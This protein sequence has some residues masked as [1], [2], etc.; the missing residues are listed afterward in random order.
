MSTHTCPYGNYIPQKDCAI[1]VRMMPN[2][3]ETV[4][5]P[6][7]SDQRRHPA[8]TSNTD[9]EVEVDFDSRALQHRQSPRR[10]STR[11]RAS[12]RP[13]FL[14]LLAVVIN[15]LPKTKWRNHIKLINTA[16]TAPASSCRGRAHP[17]PSSAFLSSLPSL[18]AC[19]QPIPHTQPLYPKPYPPLPH[20]A[21]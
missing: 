17:A 6:S 13:I 4:P 10:I 9:V 1:P 15:R 12:A 14:T 18:T 16:T 7:G 20:F 5:R 2:Y 21:T 3:S 11:P 19:P 8:P